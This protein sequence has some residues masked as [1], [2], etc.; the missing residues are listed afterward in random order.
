M[1]LTDYIAEFF[2]NKGVKHVFGLTG[3]A[4]VHLFDSV[5]RHPNMEAIFNHHE[6]AGAFAAEAYAKVTNNIGVAFTTTGPGATNAITGLAA[7]WLDSVPCVYISGQARISHTTQGKPIRQ[8]GTQQ[9][10]I[11]P[12]VK[13]LTG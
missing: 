1:K 13:S 10:D 11:I 2:S 4:V 3:G 6:Q 7:A 8:L 9:L 5:A 12:V